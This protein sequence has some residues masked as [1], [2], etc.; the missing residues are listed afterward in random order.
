MEKELTGYNFATTRR[1]TR[2]HIV[3][4]RAV[5]QGRAMIGATRA[6]CGVVLLRVHP[7]PTVTTWVVVVGIR[8]AIPV[9]A[10]VRCAVSRSYKSRYL[11]TFLL[12][13]MTSVF[14]PPVGISALFG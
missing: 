5:A 13:L 8:V 6:S 4:V 10:L 14:L 2:P 3:T 7:P 11:F 12:F 1:V 9:R